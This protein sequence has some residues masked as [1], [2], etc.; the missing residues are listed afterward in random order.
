MKLIQVKKV[1]L[2]RSTSECFTV[3]ICLIS[4]HL[5]SLDKSRHACAGVS[6]CRRN[7]FARL[8][9][10]AA[11]ATIKTLNGR[12]WRYLNCSINGEIRRARRT[13]RFCCEG[14]KSSP[15]RQ[16]FTASPR[17][18]AIS[19]AFPKDQSLTSRSR[20]TNGAAAFSPFV[21]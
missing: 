10:R 7:F 14:A 16:V 12:N 21:H 9:A 4:V 17:F 5:G 11:S 19:L 1:Q 20:L 6:E 8:S 18:P 2:R 3:R 13:R 15:Q